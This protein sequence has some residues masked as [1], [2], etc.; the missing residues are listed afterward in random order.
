M[1]IVERVRRFFTTSEQYGAI[2][3]RSPD[4]GLTEDEQLRGDPGANEPRPAV[5]EDV[6][7]P[8]S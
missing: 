5:D 6:R 3:Q 7:P 1:G 2:H 4:T 8:L